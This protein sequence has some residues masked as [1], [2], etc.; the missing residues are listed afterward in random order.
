MR[1]LKP[2]VDL[3]SIGVGDDACVEMLETFADEGKYY[4]VGEME[5]LAQKLDF[6]TRKSLVRLT[7]RNVRSTEGAQEKNERREEQ[8]LIEDAPLA[9]EIDISRC[10]GQSCQACVGACTLSAVREEGGIVT[11]QPDACV[12]CGNCESVCPVDAIHPIEADGCD[13][14]P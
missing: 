14:L 6:V 12:G 11:I 10:L 2:N 1:G 5:S 13:D 3:Y 7:S 4:V 8:A 9:R